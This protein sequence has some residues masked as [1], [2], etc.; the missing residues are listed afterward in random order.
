MKVLITGASGFVGS[1]MVDFLLERDFEVVGTFNTKPLKNKD[2]KQYPCD[3]NQY[4][5]VKE[6]MKE[7]QPKYIYHLAGPAFIPD[8][9]NRPRETI[10]TI[11]S[12]T[13][14]V[15]EA[16][17]E[18]EIDTK[19]LYVGSANEYGDFNNADLPLREDATLYPLSPYAVGKASASLLCYQYSKMYDLPIIRVRPF[20]HIGPGQS[21]RF[22]C[23]SF[24]KQIVEIERGLKKPQLAVG[25]LE[26]HRDFLD[27][28]DV[29]NAYWSILDK[30]RAGEVYNVCSGT[31]V[32][33][34]DV[35]NKLIKNSNLR[36]Q[37]EVIIS[38]DK[39]RNNDF[40]IIYGDCSKLKEAT[41]WAP[42]YSLEK[43]L[44]DILQYW[45]ETL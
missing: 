11:V 3:I 36:D 34:K 40:S 32:V 28:R 29:V 45:R 6:I 38:S 33:V 31:T 17:R 18:T 21:E 16:V 19:I 10:N 42:Q 23:S 43:T 25:N 27:V 13:L 26:A 4:D 30:G 12:G 14:N 9:F 37:I 7:V 2:L 44:E 1:H 8:S 24:A 39:L 35:L 41:E 15:L 22:V 5:E 20:N